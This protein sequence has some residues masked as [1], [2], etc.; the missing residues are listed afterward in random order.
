MKKIMPWF[1]ATDIG[2]RKSNQDSFAAVEDLGLWVLCDGMGGHAAGAEAAARAVEVIEAEV[3][4]GRNLLEAVELAHLAVGQL[5]SELLRD[6][7]TS[8][9]PGTTVVAL[10]TE[11]DKYEIV[12]VGDSRAW[13][14][15]GKTFACLT[16]DHTVV[17]DMVN[18]GDLTE[19]EALRHPQRHQLSQA[20]GADGRGKLRPGR[21]FGSWNP[22]TEVI[23]LTSDGAFCH[24]SPSLAA[25]LLNGAQEPEEIVT[26]MIAESLRRGGEDNVTV[27]AVGNRVAHGAA[28]RMNSTPK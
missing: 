22:Q 26:R 24:E 12:W 21:I 18:W 11:L 10:R 1:G 15:D 19:D 14:W 8:R 25:V 2:R 27:V 16:T 4:G 6:D 3:R 13:A 7:E 17:Q 20:L 5:G 28:V 9:R 23:I